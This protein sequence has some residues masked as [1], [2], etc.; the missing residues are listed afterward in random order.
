[1]ISFLTL[2]FNISSSLL[3]QFSYNI[4]HG[5][6]STYFFFRSV[7]C[8][9][10]VFTFTT[11]DSCEHAICSLIEKRPPSDQPFLILDLIKIYEMVR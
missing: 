6:I 9:F 4:T 5:T 10:P 3:I 2:S 7:V 8:C 1:M 11:V